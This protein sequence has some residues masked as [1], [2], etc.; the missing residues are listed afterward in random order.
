MASGASSSW[1]QYARC[2]P[3]RQLLPYGVFTLPSYPRSPRVSRRVLHGVP[4]APPHVI[5]A[6]FRHSCA[7]MTEE[8]E[9]ELAA[10]ARG[11][12]PPT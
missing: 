4:R 3:C 9:C 11:V 1:T 5:S 10:A 8:G 2:Q 7:R 12:S 6:L